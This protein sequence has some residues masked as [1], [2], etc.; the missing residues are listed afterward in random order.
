MYGGGGG[1]MGGMSDRFGSRAGPFGSSSASGMNG[2]GPVGGGGPGLN[3]FGS[4]GHGHGH[5]HG[6]HGHGGSSPYD[7]TG[8]AS[9]QFQATD[10]LRQDSTG[11]SYLSNNT[12]PGSAASGAHGKSAGGTGT[13]PSKVNGHGHGAP[14]SRIGDVDGGIARSCQSIR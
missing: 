14:G 2:F 9:P 4:A 10:I 1:D 12:S 11:L 8:D 3:G 5:S 6:G 7:Y 13:N